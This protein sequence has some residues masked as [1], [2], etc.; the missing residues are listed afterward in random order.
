LDTLIQVT[1]KANTRAIYLAQN[2]FILHFLVPIQ[3]KVG[4]PD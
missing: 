2:I 3:H 4:S 1:G